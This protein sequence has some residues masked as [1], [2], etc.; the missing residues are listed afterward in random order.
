[1]VGETES[2]A[3]VPGTIRGDYSHVSYDY[4]NKKKIVVKNVVHASASKEDAKK[5]IS[6]W[7]SI[8]DLCNYK[9]V[10]EEHTF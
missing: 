3:A 7:F 4:A 10:H 1:M 6:L 9:T 5:E 2:K 8:E